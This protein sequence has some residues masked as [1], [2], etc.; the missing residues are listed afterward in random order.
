ML[1]PEKVYVFRAPTDNYGIQVEKL[2]LVLR[3]KG[4]EE[5]LGEICRSNNVVFLAFIGS[6]VWGEQHKGSDVD[7]AIEFLTR[8]K[9]KPS[10]I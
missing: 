2:P 5:K 3:K 10:W 7:I 9:A 8:A 6:F 1:I 4:L